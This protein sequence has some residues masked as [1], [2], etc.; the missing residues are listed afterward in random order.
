MSEYLGYV[1]KKKEKKEI[2]WLKLE[3]EFLFSEIDIL[4]YTN[5]TQFTI[6]FEFFDKLK[7]SKLIEIVTLSRESLVGKE[8]KKVILT[9]RN[10]N[11]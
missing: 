2:D 9:K 3:K 5:R 11:T 1:K 7:S 10:R 4:F 8:K 6:N